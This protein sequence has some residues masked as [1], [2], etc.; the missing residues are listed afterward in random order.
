[1]ETV[2]GPDPQLRGAKPQI[3][4]GNALH[5][6]DRLIVDDERRRAV[7]LDRPDEIGPIRVEGLAALDRGFAKAVI[8][9]SRNAGESGRALAIA[10]I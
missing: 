5:H 1:V 10:R 9:A 4:A 3:G 7:S 2:R 6:A 8:S